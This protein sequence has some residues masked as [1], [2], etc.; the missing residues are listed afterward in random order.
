MLDAYKR[1]NLAL[2]PSPALREKTA[3]SM[4]AKRR[5]KRH[6]PLYMSAAA[7]A[8]ALVFLLSLMPKP[9]GDNHGRVR[10]LRTY[11][12]SEP[13]YPDY[14]SRIN[15][16][17]ME[18]HGFFEEFRQYWSQLPKEVDKDF[19]R[20]AA[21]FSQ[22]SSQLVLTGAEEN[23]IYSPVNLWTALAMLAETTGGTSRQQILNALGVDSLETLRTQTQALWLRSYVS[24]GTVATI[25]AGSLWLNKGLSYEKDTLDILSTYYFAGSY[26]VDMGTR[27]ADKAI[28]DWLDAQT[29]GLDRKSTRLNSSH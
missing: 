12:I 11:A 14:P 7:A 27:K 2:H 1:A 15:N 8:L 22:V 3:A 21:R 28:A 13:V 17:G 24:D 29:G 4:A 25:P 9:S 19:A 23:R 10:S 18:R 16:M 20:Q 6:W 5:P 26:A